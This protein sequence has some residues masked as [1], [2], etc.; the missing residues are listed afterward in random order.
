MRPVRGGC[1]W[2]L[3][4]AVILTVVPAAPAA[5]E[6]TLEIDAGYAASFIPGAEVPVRVRVSADRLVRG[7]L[8]VGIGNPENGI[9][10]AMAVEIPGGSQKEFLL[11]APSGFNQSPDVVARLRQGNQ[12]VASGQTQIRA[13]TDT[14]LVGVLP[15]ALRGRP[16]PALAPLAVDAGSARFAAIG[17]GELEQAPASL[18][19]LSTL[20]ADVDEVGRLSPAARA[21]VLRWID[22][23]GRLLVDAAK[24]QTVPGLPDTWQPGTRGRATAGLGEVVATDGAVAAGRWSGLVE[25]SGRLVSSNRFGG[26]FPMASSLAQDA[27]LRTPEIAWLVGFLVL[28]VVVAGPVVFF[29]VRRRGRPELAWVAV[30]LVAV[31]FTSGSWVVGRNLRNATELVHASVLSTTAGGPVATSYVGVFSRSGETARIGFPAGWSSGSYAVPGQAAVPTTINH[32]SDGPDARLPLDPGQFGMVQGTGPAPKDVGSLEITAGSEAGGAVSGTVRNVTP[33]QLESVVVFAGTDVTLV[34]TVAPGQQ[35]PFNMP[36][37]G[38]R[39]DGGGAEFRIWGGMGSATA[40]SAADLG[41][42]QATVTAS[43]ANFLSPDAIVAAGWTRD[44]KPEVRTGSSVARPEGRTLVL[45]RQAVAIAPAGPGAIAARRVI[46]R[47]P[48][49]Q[50]R[51]MAGGGSVIRFMLP[52]G[53]DTSKLVLRSSFGG[54]EFWQEGA[55]KQASCDAPGCRPAEIFACGP[56]GCP[57][58]PGR[59]LPFAPNGELTVPASSVRDGVVYVRLPG[60]ATGGGPIPVTLGRSA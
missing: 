21:G 15:G 31:L 8:E 3:A 45:G 2:A 28:Y 10:A 48:F 25:P 30:P 46:V 55:W 26:E 43:G 14:E 50:G 51:P 7:T 22:G 49:R 60:P 59:P 24:G 32:T 39:M 42:W 41:L 56:G 47:D 53:A 1:W 34:G 23:G 6:T 58:G 20:I 4:A 17:A 33:F 12:L 29:A 40:E 16:V 9:P 37:V 52:A 35:R 18:G 38:Q 13:I 27:G 57:P 44:Y 5:A 19:P 36:A 54:A 11:T